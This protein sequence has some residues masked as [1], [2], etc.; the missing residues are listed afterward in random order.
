MKMLKTLL[1]KEKKEKK[2]KKSKKKK[3]GKDKKSKVFPPSYVC[4]YIYIHIYT[5]VYAYILPECGFV[6][7][8]MLSA[9]VFFW[10][11]QMRLHTYISPAI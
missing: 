3:E 5:Y 11:L 9:C 7:V 4:I 10:C 2:D 6:R 8:C 1:K